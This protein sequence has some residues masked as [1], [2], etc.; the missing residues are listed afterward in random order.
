MIMAV[1]QLGDP[2]GVRTQ[3]TAMLENYFPASDDLIRQVIGGLVSGS[4]TFGVVAVVSLLIGANGLFRA[5]DRAVNR[6]FGA[7]G[8]NVIGA[9]LAEIAL[10]TLLGRYFYFQSS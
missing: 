8:R 2:E 9:T 7:S 4:L 1:I 6:V 5:T 3:L 10:A